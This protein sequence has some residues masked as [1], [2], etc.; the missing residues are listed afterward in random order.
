[1]NDGSQFT[2]EA[3]NYALSIP[4]EVNPKRDLSDT[5]PW[6]SGPEDSFRVHARAWPSEGLV[7]LLG[8]E[9]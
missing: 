1:M 5:T 3:G 2:F 9:T 4:I 8:P 6:K 7:E